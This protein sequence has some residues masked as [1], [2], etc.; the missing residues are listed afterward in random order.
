MGL[1]SEKAI[2]A[3]LARGAL[4][5]DPPPGDEHFD[6]DSVAVHVGERIY[7]WK[8]PAGGATLTVPLW[9]SGAANNPFDM[10]SFAAE[11]L[12]VVPPDP[13]GLVTIRPHTFYLADL[14]QYIALPADL[15]V[16]IQGRST[17]ARLGMGVHVT[18]PHAHAGWDGRLALEIYNFGPFNIEL[19]RGAPVGQLT[20]WRVEDPASS[21]EE[22]RPG[23]FTGQERAS[24]AKE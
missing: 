8:Q 13:D 5:I 11:H 24:G 15:A 2:R 14:M 4:K 16:H 12:A 10:K 18:A 22:I 6:S 9:R 20:F 3:A 7:T 1:L 23:I 21:A 17:L 19:K